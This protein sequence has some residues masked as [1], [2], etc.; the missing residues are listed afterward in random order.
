M[1]DT[2]NDL[3][4]EGRAMV[5]DYGRACHGDDVRQIAIEGSALDAYL[6]RLTTALADAQRERDAALADVDRAERERDAATADWP[7]DAYFT[8]DDI[9]PSD[10]DLRNDR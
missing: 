1:S 5:D 6:V 2:T 3:L 9:A 10:Y 7:R 8:R 4:A